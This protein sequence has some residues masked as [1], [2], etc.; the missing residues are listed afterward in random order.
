MKLKVIAEGIE[1]E[2]QALFLKERNCDC[3]Q[4]FF[5]SRAVPPHEITRM[6]QNRAQDR[7]AA[8]MMRSH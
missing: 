7:N 1:T 8:A 3:A 5:F 2:Q 6:L 4:G